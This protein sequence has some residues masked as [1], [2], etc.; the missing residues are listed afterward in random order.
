MNLKK[1]ETN[2]KNDIAD[3]SIEST[4]QIT[5]DVIPQITAQ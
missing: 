5:A 1:W 4:N 3:K 2:E